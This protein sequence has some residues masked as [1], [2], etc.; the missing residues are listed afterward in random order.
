MEVSSKSFDNR[1]D[2]NVGDARPLI[3]EEISEVP[4]LKLWAKFDSEGAVL[5]AT[6]EGE[7]APSFPK[8]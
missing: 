8:K 5:G 2:S 6:P 1:A 7:G 4:R 3:P